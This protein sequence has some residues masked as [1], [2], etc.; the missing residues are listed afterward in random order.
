MIVKQLDI[1][2]FTNTTSLT[3]VKHFLF[4]LAY[5]ELQRMLSQL[6]LKCIKQQFN[7][8]EHYINVLLVELDLFIHKE[9]EELFPMLEE[10]DAT[11]SKAKNC[12]PFKEVKKHYTSMQQ[13]IGMLLITAADQ[14]NEQLLNDIRRI[15]S[16][17]NEI[18]KQKD[19][20]FFVHFKNCTGCNEHH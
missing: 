16:K 10:L 3:N 13:Y 2:P 20:Y 18:Q 4:E 7:E 9:Q 11:H 19:K 15:E 5:P 14:S 1:Q 8:E 12:K 6:Q 17:L